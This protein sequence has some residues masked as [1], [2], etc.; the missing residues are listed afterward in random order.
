MT[1][2]VIDRPKNPPIDSRIR[3][4]RIDVRRREG[5]RRLRR[6]AAVLA[7][8]AL[9]LG[10][11][12]LVR[13]PA[14]DVD[15]IVV[16][17]ASR[18]PVDEVLASLAVSRGD[19]LVDID[20]NQ[21]AEGVAALPWVASVDV[22]RTWGGTIAVDVVER[23]PDLVA[24]DSTGQLWLVDADGAVL[25][26]ADDSIDPFVRVDGIDPPA[27]GNAIDSGR[28]AALGLAV[29]LPEHVRPLVAAVEVDE[30]DEIWIR[31]HARPGEVDADGATRADGGLIRF[32][33]GRALEEQI[34][35]AAAVLD[36]V[37]LTDLAVVD[38]RVPSNP[39]VTRTPVSG[40]SGGVDEATTA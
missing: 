35:A 20:V 33:D 14:L 22:E 24:S 32:G 5:R 8:S 13:S 38:V 31:L 1:G 39:V 27:P 19:A 2:S 40:A 17:G 25:G 21:S 37:D 15:E 18:T 7:V 3:A 4:R 23:T 28:S 30:A 6:L 34:R 26:A 9:V 10:A 12:A 16:T 36:Q 29:G 11:W